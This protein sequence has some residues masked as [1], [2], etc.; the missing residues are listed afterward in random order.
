MLVLAGADLFWPPFGR[1]FAGWVAAPSVD[2]GMV[3]PGA[4]E[5]I[6]KAAY[7]SIRAFRALVVVDGT[8]ETWMRGLTA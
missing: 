4:S 6:D 5:L 3:Q 8:C 2:P 7:D 1:I